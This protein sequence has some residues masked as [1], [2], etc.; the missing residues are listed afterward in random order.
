MSYLVQILS[1]GLFHPL[2]SP[3]IMACIILPAASADK[4]EEKYAPVSDG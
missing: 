1:P 3:L 2:K 4:V